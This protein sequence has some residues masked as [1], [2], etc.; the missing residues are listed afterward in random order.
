M[1]TLLALS[2]VPTGTGQAVTIQPA[3]IPETYVD[4]TCYHSEITL[5]GTVA[6]HDQSINEVACGSPQPPTTCSYTMKDVPDSGYI[7][8]SW[9]SSGEVSITGSGASVTLYVHV[10][11]SGRYQG[12]VTATV[13]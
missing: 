10:P 8:S 13:S 2:M 11:G 9:S 7:F 6:C 4:F 5:D 3:Y 12:Y 1:T